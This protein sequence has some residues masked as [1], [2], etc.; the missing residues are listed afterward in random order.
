MENLYDYIL[1][2]LRETPDFYNAKISFEQYLHSLQEAAKH[3]RQSYK[4]NQVRVDYSDRKIQA[5]YLILYYPH[6]VQM[7]LEILRLSPEL[8]SFGKQIN[9]CFFCSGPCSEIAGLAQFLTE[10]GQNT[11]SLVVNVY[12]IAADAWKPSRTLTK[13][14]I[15]PRLW[16]GNISGRTTNFNLCSMNAFQPIAEVIENCDLF[17][18][19]N[20][21]NEIWNTSATRDNIQFLL[22][23][24]PLDSC[25]IIADLMYD[26]NRQIIQ[27]ITEIAKSRNDYKIIQRSEGL[28]IA[29]LFGRKTIPSIVTQNLLTGED[30]LIPR[31]KIKFLFLVIRKGEYESE[32]FLDDIF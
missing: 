26:Q 3:L 23:R 1:E 24:A 25:I 9:A 19:Q 2:G 31:S 29:S 5:A 16:R 4:S 30:G 27:E 20:C 13:N 10:H 17:I 21:L 6:Y 15:L 32:D 14:F 22:D 8:F 11:E 7:T 18:F 28:E 12:D